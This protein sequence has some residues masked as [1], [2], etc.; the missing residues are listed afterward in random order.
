MK[1][2][3]ISLLSKHKGLF[4]ARNVN[5]KPYGFYEKSP[6]L[7]YASIFRKS[8]ALFVLSIREVFV[9][10]KWEKYA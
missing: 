7:R 2:R 6:H 1:D 9:R 5:T 4:Q 10:E 8:V 3:D